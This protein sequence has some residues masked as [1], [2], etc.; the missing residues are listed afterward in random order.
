MSGDNDPVELAPCQSGVA[1]SLP[2]GT[3]EPWCSRWLECRVYYNPDRAL[4]ATGWFA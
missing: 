4:V 2:L 1:A 3:R